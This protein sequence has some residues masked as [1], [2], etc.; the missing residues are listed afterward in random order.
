MSSWP[1]CSCSEAEHHGGEHEWNRPARLLMA[2]KQR[3]SGRPRDKIHTSEALPQDLLLPT[4]P[5]LLKFPLPLNSATSWG[6]SLQH[7]SLCGT[8]RI[9]NVTTLRVHV[10]KLNHQGD[11]IRRWGIWEMIRAQGQNPHE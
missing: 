6:P 5:R 4:R 8:F 1:H 10:L 11:G 9:P 2:R 7:M 3:Q